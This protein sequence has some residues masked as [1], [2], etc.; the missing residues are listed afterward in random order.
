MV[1]KERMI[2]IIRKLAANIY[3]NFCVPTMQSVYL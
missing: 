1:K 2:T 3:L